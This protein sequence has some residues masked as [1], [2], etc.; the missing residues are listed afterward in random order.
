MQDANWHACN[1]QLQKVSIQ[2]SETHMICKIQIC[3][4]KY[5]VKVRPRQNWYAYNFQQQKVAVQ[6]S[7]SYMICEYIQ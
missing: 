4:C 6:V 2:V 5:L 7:E 1:L 3:V